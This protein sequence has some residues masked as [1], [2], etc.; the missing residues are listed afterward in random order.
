MD[1]QTFEILDEHYRACVR[2]WI[3]AEK[4]DEKT[5]MINALEDIRNIKYN[6]F[7]MQ[8]SEENLL[9][10]DTVRQY[11]ESRLMDI[12]GKQWKEHINEI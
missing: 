5:A 2:Y 4:C 7:R 9:D 12:Y 6:P 8:A 3:K 11:K 10:V 1:K